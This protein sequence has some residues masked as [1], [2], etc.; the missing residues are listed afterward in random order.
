MTA[1]MVADQ[2][3][4]RMTTGK[5]ISQTKDLPKAKLQASVALDPSKRAAQKKI[6]LILR[7]FGTLFLKNRPLLLVSRPGM[8]SPD[9]DA[10]STESCPVG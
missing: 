3:M 1:S 8:L 9:A 2:S 4:A 6:V 5:S 7:G 10:S